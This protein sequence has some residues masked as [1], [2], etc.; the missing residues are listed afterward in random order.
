MIRD[1]FMFLV[2]GYKG[3]RAAHIKEAFIE[4]FNMMEDKLH[5]QMMAMPVQEKLELLMEGYQM[6]KEKREAP[7]EQFTE[8]EPKVEAHDEAMDLVDNMT[9]NNAAKLLVIKR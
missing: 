7:E 8:M 3:K 9:P 6:E 2:M 5:N 1:G 4:A